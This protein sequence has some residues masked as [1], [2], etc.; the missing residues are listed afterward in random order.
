MKEYEML[1][2]VLLSFLES[3]KKEQLESLKTIDYSQFGLIHTNFC[4]DECKILKRAAKYYRNFNPN[5]Q[6]SDL[7]VKYFS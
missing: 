5:P 1:V 2:L 3:C 4:L 6:V 7:I